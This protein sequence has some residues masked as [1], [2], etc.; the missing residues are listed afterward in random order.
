MSKRKLQ[1]ELPR[2]Q[3]SIR[4]VVLDRWGRRFVIVSGGVDAV[5]ARQIGPNGV[6]YD[7]QCLLEVDAI[8]NTGV[9]FE[10]DL[11]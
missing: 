8:K 11:A 10:G 1:P 7:S 3:P 4:S 9:K 6:L 2:I 5:H